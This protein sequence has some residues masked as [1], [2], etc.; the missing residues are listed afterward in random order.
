MPTELGTKAWSWEF[1]HISYV[2]KAGIQLLVVT[3]VPLLPQRVHYQGAESGAD[4]AHGTSA[5]FPSGKQAFFHH[6]PS[7]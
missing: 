1:N 3:A 2:E 7:Q 4:T 6:S 5:G